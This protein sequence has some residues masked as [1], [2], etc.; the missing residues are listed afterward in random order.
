[1]LPNPQIG[2]EI[3]MLPQSCQLTTNGHEFLVFDSGIGNPEKI[4]TFASDLGLQCLFECDHWYPN[5]T[6][7]NAEEYFHVFLDYYLIKPRQLTPGF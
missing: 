2:E 3:P 5:D 7:K 1:M 6:C 4:F